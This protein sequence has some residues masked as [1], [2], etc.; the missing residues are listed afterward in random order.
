MWETVEIEIESLRDYVWKSDEKL[1]KVVH[2]EEIIGKGKKKDDIREQ[3]QEKYKEKALCRM[4]L[5]NT[6]KGR[7][8]STWTWLNQGEF[9]K[10]TEGM[11]M[12]AQDQALTTRYI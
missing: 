10:E 1:L 6:I 3:R 5:V 12:V 11:I 9:K 4:F 8:A 2:A 7:D